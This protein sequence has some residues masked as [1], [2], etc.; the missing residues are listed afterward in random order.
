MNFTIGTLLAF[1]FNASMSAMLALIWAISAKQLH[2]IQEDAKVIFEEGKEPSF[3]DSTSS[4]S[5]SSALD[6]PT[7]GK[8][9]RFLLL[10]MFGSAAFWLVFGSFFG[11]IASLKLHCSGQVLLATEL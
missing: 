4:R 6:A 11:L 10:F 5:S 3:D 9:Y 2:V 1:S 7:L 8:R